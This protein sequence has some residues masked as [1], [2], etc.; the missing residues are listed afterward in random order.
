MDAIKLERSDLL[1]SF[2]RYV[3]MSQCGWN[4]ERMQS[5]GYC[6]SILPILKRLHPDPEDFK[7][8]FI[9]NLNFF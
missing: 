7:E 6:Y 5:V 3:F 9:T 1:K 8:A 2:W 4:Y